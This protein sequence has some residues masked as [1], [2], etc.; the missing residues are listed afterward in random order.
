MY[1]LGQS[2]TVFSFVLLSTALAEEK[3]YTITFDQCRSLST[4]FERYSITGA[5]AE[6]PEFECTRSSQKFL[7]TQAGSKDLVRLTESVRSDKKKTLEDEKAQ[8]RLTFTESKKDEP[9]TVVGVFYQNAGN[10][11]GSKICRGT[12]ASPEFL[13]YM[14]KPRFIEDKTHEDHP[15]GI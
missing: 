3:K 5:V 14:K 8:I 4:D 10:M 2:L 7:C 15:D 11:I 6:G 1:L 12:L 9:G 13:E